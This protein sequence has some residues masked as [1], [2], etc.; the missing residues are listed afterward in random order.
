[1]NGQWEAVG[2]RVLKTPNRADLVIQARADRLLQLDS[3]PLDLVRGNEID[4]HLCF[5]LSFGEHRAGAVG[6]PKL[7]AESDQTRRGLDGLTQCFNR[8]HGMKLLDAE[9]Q[10]AK[11]SRTTFSLVM[12]DL[13]S[14]KSVNDEYGH[15]CGDALLSAVGK[16]MHELL[17]NS[18]VKVRYGGEEFLIML[19]DTP[20]RGAIHVARI[21]NSELGNLS[22]K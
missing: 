12:M 22:V 8:T 2:G 13:D 16:K 1:M 5:G 17:R 20:L 3:E 11:R 9:L 14:A 19:P 15:L 4:G 7:F 21:L 18:D 10:R 6:L